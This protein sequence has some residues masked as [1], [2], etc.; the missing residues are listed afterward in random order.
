MNTLTRRIAA[1]RWVTRSTGCTL[2]GRSC[3]PHR[4]PIRLE[5]YVEDGCYV[6]RAELPVIDPAKH[7]ELTV[8]NGK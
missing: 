7:I 3:V 2:R 6:V 4:H 8:A 1:T 5:E